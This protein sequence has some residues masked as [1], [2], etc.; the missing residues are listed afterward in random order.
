MTD[1]RQLAFLAN[2]PPLTREEQDDACFRV[3]DRLWAEIGSLYDQYEEEQDLSYADVGRRISR[4]RSQVQR[5]LAAPMNMT[6]SSA[7]LLA[8]GLDADLLVLLQPRAA[9]EPMRANRIHPCE[10]AK[11]RVEQFRALDERALGF[12]ETTPP[13]NAAA[14]TRGTATASVIRWSRH[15]PA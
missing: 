13:E 4:S 7:G 11:A 14:P 3:R 1:P 12:E 5:W 9:G 10:A 6:L 15:G 2:L 8:E